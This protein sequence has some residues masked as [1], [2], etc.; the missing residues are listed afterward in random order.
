MP[1][2]VETYKKYKAKGFT[3]YSVSLDNDGGA[4][5]NAIKGLGMEWENHVSDLKGWKCEASVRYGIQ[6]IPAAF[7][8][9]KNGVIVATNLRGDALGQKVA[10][11]LQ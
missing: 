9:D 2:V 5:K 8:L 11:L 10:E 7:L 1:N 3:V 6:G 4:W